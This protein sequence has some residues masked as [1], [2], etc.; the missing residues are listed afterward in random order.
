VSSLRSNTNSA[1]MF[2]HILDELRRR[3]EANGGCIAYVE[4]L[5]VIPEGMPFK[6][7][8]TRCLEVLKALGLKIVDVP[9]KDSS[10]QSPSH[11][12]ADSSKSRPESL[13][14]TYLRHVGQVKLLSREE[15]TQAF[16]AISDSESA[17]REVFNRFLFSPRMYLRVLDRIDEKGDRF[18]HIVGGAF[19]GKRNVYVSLIPQLRSRVRSILDRFEEACAR[20]DDVKDVRHDLRRCYDDLSF[21]QVVL[22]KMCDDAHEKIYLPYLR[23][24]KHVREG[25][26]NVDRKELARLESLFG[27]PPD[28]FVSE[29]AEVRRSMESIRKARIR[30][31]EAN[32]RLVVFVAKR[33]I[34]RGIPF[35]DL[36]QEGNV[37][38]MNAVLKFNLKRGHKF[39]TYAIW[40]I[41]QAIARA[42]ENQARTI[43]VPVHV[44]EQIGKLKA[45]ESRLSQGLCRKVSDT[46]LA[47]ELGLSEDR[48]KELRKMAQ[49]TV[50]LDGKIDDSEG[51]SYG[52]FIPD[53]KTEKPYEATERSLM[54]ERVMDVIKGLTVRERMVIDSRYGLTDGTPRTLDEV[55]M[56]FNVTRERIRQIEISA[57]KK[58]RDP[59]V[60]SSLAEFAAAVRH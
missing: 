21:K 16:G 4:L 14:G 50:S 55:G 45:A 13:V 49:G 46:E 54:R 6:T 40:W 9:S 22:E 53:D 27:M 44:I 11:G 15:E 41:R 31:I 57:L 47:L 32:Q 5:S 25:D 26:P 34:G 3:S 7:F 23:L 20:G 36:V 18:D 19:S 33:F 39:S 52:D 42:I 10:A 43:R 48:V 1:N 2:A 59:K 37:G 58:L 56:M 12:L 17:M 8:P 35:L 38:L 51:T 24:S 28:E 60:M 30:I 29:F